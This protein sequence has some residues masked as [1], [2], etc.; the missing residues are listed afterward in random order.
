MQRADRRSKSL[1][2][3]APHRMINGVTAIG[4]KCRHAWFWQS[5]TAT[6]HCGASARVHRFAPL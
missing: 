4:A 1:D 2:A 3:S 5:P 6:A